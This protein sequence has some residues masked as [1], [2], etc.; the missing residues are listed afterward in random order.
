MCKS[1]GR[2][3]ELNLWGFSSDPQAALK[4]QNNLIS[5][6][7][8]EPNIY[9]DLACSCEECCLRSVY[10]ASCGLMVALHLVVYYL[11]SLAPWLMIT[12][13]KAADNMGQ[14]QALRGR[15]RSPPWVS[16]YIM[17]VC[18]NTYCLQNEK[19][20]SQEKILIHFS[21]GI[22]SRKSLRNTP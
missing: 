20:I 14:G 22:F 4:T 3:R 19:L 16:K 15:I 9:F 10:L 2:E 6:R 5:L 18:T 12:H 21:L 1:T 7:Q 8:T 17:G 13:K 11:S